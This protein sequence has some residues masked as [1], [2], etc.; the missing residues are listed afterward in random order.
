LS[1]LAVSLCHAVEPA[2]ASASKAEWDKYDELFADG[3]MAQ[4]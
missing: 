2:S 1:G 4:V 3:G